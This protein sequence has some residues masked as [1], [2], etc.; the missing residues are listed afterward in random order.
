[1]HPRL[2]SRKLINFVRCK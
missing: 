1:M 2:L